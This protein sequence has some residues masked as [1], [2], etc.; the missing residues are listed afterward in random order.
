MS[1][2]QAMCSSFKEELFRG[3]HDLSTD[4]IKLALFD[5]NATLD[6]STTVYSTTD[7]VSGTGYTAGGNTLSGVNI[8]LTGTTALVDFDD[9]AWPSVLITPRG[10]LIYN[11]SKGNRA[12]AVVDF[13]EDKAATNSNFVARFPAGDAAHAIIRIV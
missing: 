6:A 8:L 2:S 9:S 3:V 5:S 1:I 10:G 12:I 4:V 7:E 11:A 13:G